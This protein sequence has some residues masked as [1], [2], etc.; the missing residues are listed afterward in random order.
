MSFHLKI[1]YILKGN[2]E[3]SPPFTLNYIF[4]AIYPL[5]SLYILKKKKLRANLTNCYFPFKSLCIFKG[6]SEAS[7][8]YPLYANF[9]LFIF[10]LY[11]KCDF[12]KKVFIF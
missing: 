7:I 1:L 3:A 10:L 2:S 5:K 6:T 4:K 9:P 11:F 12:P 8:I